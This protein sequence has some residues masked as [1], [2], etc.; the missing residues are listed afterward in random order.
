MKKSEI[1]VCTPKQLPKSLRIAAARTA[2]LM[3]PVNRPRVEHMAGLMRGFRATPQRIAVMTTSYWGAKGVSLTVDFLDNAPA[4]LR[5]RI[6]EHMNA[7]AKTANVN[8]APGKTDP[9][10]RIA[11]AGG[12]QGGY[13]SYVG[14]QILHIPAGEPTMNLEGFT[15]QTDDAEF[16]R[17]VRHETGHTLGFPHEHMRRE[18]VKKIDRR[19]AIAYYK[20][21]DGWTE[22]DTIDQVLTPLEDSAIEGTIA[23]PKSIMCY[24]IPEEITKDGKPIIGGLDIDEC[25]YAFAA[26]IYP[27]PAV[28]AKRR[29]KR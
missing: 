15:M 13:W 19:K 23:D 1:L 5:R 9:Q 2:V 24:Q 4:D 17:V 22:Q 3:N 11:R 27:K 29:R 25:D 14:T 21:M 20:R 16:Y 12:K 8:F 18:L 26:Q 7:W 6:L 28:A 10:V